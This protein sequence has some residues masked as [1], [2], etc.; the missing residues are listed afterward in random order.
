MSL[1][2]V[3]GGFGAASRVLANFLSFSQLRVGFLLPS[4]LRV[5]L[6]LNNLRRRYNWIPSWT[7]MR[8]DQMAIPYQVRGGRKKRQRRSRRFKVEKN[9][10]PLMEMRRV[11]SW[12]NNENPMH[13]HTQVNPTGT[14]A[15][16]LRADDKSGRCSTCHL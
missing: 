10:P 8:K 14:L 1:W 11:S 5:G 4:S 12:P 6:N 3:W 15:D 16:Y 2:G 13:L 7:E 9:Q